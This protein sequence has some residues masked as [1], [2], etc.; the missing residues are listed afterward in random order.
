LRISAATNL[1]LRQKRL[2]FPQHARHT[3][4]ET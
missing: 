2:L 3:E 4:F 1:L